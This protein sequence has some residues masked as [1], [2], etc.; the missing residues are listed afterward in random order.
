[1]GIGEPAAAVLVR[2]GKEPEK[3]NLELKRVEL[4]D[5]IG[6]REPDLVDGYLIRRKTP[7]FNYG[8]IRR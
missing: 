6:N 7:G 4:I 5:E 8:D 2:V 1:M 3:I